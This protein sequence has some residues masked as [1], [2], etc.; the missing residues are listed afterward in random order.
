[1]RVTYLKI[2]AAGVRNF[3]NGQLQDVVHQDCI[4]SHVSLQ[5]P[6]IFSGDVGGKRGTICLLFAILLL[7]LRSI[8]L[9]ASNRHPIRTL[10]FL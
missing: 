2:F 1:M 3:P 9:S 6:L 10:G 7:I 5:T 8:L 4:A